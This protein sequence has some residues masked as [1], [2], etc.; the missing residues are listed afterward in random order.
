MEK[1]MERMHFGGYSRR[2]L[3]TGWV[4]GGVV[5]VECVNQPAPPRH[6]ATMAVVCV[7]LGPS[8]GSLGT[9]KAQGSSGDS[10]SSS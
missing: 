5:L 4:C 9:S 3:V 8:A 10:Y 6:G 1:W 7:G 2:Y